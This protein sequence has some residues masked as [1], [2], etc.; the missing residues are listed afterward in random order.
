[1]AGAALAHAA[2]LLPQLRR[3]PSLKMARTYL[4]HLATEAA[5]AH[6]VPLACVKGCS[7][8][9]RTYVSATAADVL[10]L[11]AFLRDTRQV[12]GL[13][14]LKTRLRHAS[15]SERTHLEAPPVC[16]FLEA[17]L[18][19][20]YE[21]RPSVCAAHVSTD[22]TPCKEAERRIEAG[23]DTGLAVAIPVGHIFDGAVEDITLSGLLFRSEAQFP[24]HF[25]LWGAVS[26]VLWHPE[27]VAH[28]A[29]HPAD[30]LR[31]LE[32][33]RVGAA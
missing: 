33:W 21:A 8:C 12:Q 27:S 1:L 16:P 15:K 32:P 6:P 10:L 31:I 4:R 19:S 29:D 20:V 25:A 22:V 5:A 18:C 24:A 17:G 2:T 11:S 26:A 28:W 13:E 3:I 7:H 9:C 30:L 14:Q 23:D